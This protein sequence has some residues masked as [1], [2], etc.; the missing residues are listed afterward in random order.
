MITAGFS[1]ARVPGPP[2]KREMMVARKC[3]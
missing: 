2:G 3:L 1:V